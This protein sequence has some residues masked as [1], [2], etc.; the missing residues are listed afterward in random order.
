MS[1]NQNRART[2]MLIVC[3]AS[4]L[5]FLVNLMF[6]SVD[7]PT[8]LKLKRSVG[9]KMNYTLKTLTQAK[10]NGALAGQTIPKNLFFYW[11]GDDVPSVVLDNLL[12]TLEELEPYNYCIKLITNEEVVDALM[13][14]WP[15]LSKIFNEIVLP[16]AK[17][18]IARYLWLYQYGGLY[19]DTHCRFRGGVKKLN[20]L[21]DVSYDVVVSKWLTANIRNSVLLAKPASNLMKKWVDLSEKKLW[22]QYRAECNST[23]YHR[24]DVSHLTGQMILLN[25]I[26]LSPDTCLKLTNSDNTTDFFSLK[27]RDVFGI[28][29]C[30]NT[31]S[32]FASYSV[33]ADLNHGPNM[34]KHWSR[35]QGRER[36]FGNFSSQRHCGGQNTI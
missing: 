12:A 19:A 5:C 31:D 14:E 8:L 3:L 36:L 16:S 26:C 24:Y 4:L 33:G 7:S 27:C 15:H 25:D 21:F 22:A 17:S 10:C 6:R 11:D 30:L 32:Y 35:R 9:I 29:K 18:D 1:G 2:M 13:L 28:V 34:H 23:K 20:R